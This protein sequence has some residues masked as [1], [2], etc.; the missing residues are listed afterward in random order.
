MIKNR[1]IYKLKPIIISK[2]EMT[3]R[4]M[5]LT[6][7]GIAALADLA[8]ETQGKGV[9]TLSAKALD[10]EV[11]VS[12]NYDKMKEH[13][14]K[15][16]ASDGV[17]IFYWITSKPE[18]NKPTVLLHPGSSYNHTSFLGLEKKLNDQGHP[19]IVLDPRGFG[20]SEAPAISESFT[21]KK[22]TCDL[23]E[24][25]HKEGIENPIL[26]TCSFGFMPAVNYTAETKNVSKL[27]G[28]SA[29]PCTKK[30][31][32]SETQFEIFDRVGRYVLEYPGSVA[33][34]LK[35]WVKGTERGCPDQ[36]IYEG[37]T[38]IDMFWTIA[39]Q[40]FKKLK[41][42]TTSGRAINKWDVSEQLG[43][44]NVPVHLVYGSKDMLVVPEMAGSYIKER[45]KGKC[46]V[47]IIPDAEHM[48]ATTN[49]AVVLQTLNKYLK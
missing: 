15:I 46:T 5:I 39:D 9:V 13:A 20:Y 8:L 25:L 44:I 30:T 40:P 4:K 34:A 11:G 10:R 37:K 29:T 2:M 17:D 42:N 35:H 33:T 47:D 16:T 23:G 14:Q 7:L 26:L 36:S 19:T 24:I 38:D 3:R 1:K 18:M 22:Y 48:V 28:V 6:S 21:L 31:A 12:S 27:L 43:K 41:M 49:P 32:S 45:V